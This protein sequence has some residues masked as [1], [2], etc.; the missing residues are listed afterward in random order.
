MKNKTYKNFGDAFLELKENSPDISYGKI[1]RELDITD[2]YAWNLPNRRRKAPIPKKMLVEIAKV[3]KVKPSY[4]Y[5]FRL[6]EL[7]NFIDNERRFLDYCLRQSKKFKKA[8][9]EYE[10]PI[11]EVEEEL[12]EE[13][14]ETEERF[15]KSVNNE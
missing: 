1:A 8:E 13:T 10:R 4:F 2:S 3:F 12:E 5:E 11:E 15:K 14:E 7:L 6:Q 9:V